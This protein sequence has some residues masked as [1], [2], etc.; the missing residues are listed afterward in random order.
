MFKMPRE[1]SS[2]KQQQKATK[3]RKE[4]CMWEEWDWTQHWNK[5][6]MKGG[7]NR[8]REKALI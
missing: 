4:L 2:L 8:E 1:V 5:N 3:T 6:I 7:E